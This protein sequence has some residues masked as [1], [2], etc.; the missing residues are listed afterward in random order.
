LPERKNIVNFV[1]GLHSGSKDI[2]FN[3]L[4]FYAL[5]F[6]IVGC[7]FY[8]IY[9]SQYLRPAADD[10]CFG[11]NVATFGVIKGVTHWWNSMS[12]FAFSLLLGSVLVGLPLATLPY[13]MA[14]AI[15]FLCVSFLMGWLVTGIAKPKLNLADKFFIYIHRFLLVGLFM[16][17]KY[18]HES[19][20]LWPIRNK[21][22]YLL[23]NSKWNLCN[24]VTNFYRFIHFCFKLH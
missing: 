16:G 4:W 8:V 10:Y 14:S 3:S 20:F 19:L 2:K 18:S 7:V 1:K 9:S 6:L 11:A 23:A 22:S 21:W 5:A 17:P 15:P 12:G 13:W 24:S